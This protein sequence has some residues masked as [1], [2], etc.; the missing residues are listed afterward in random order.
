MFVAVNALDLLF[1]LFGEKRFSG[2]KAE[3]RILKLAYCF[4]LLGSTLRF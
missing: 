2:R 3:I 4:L 1:A